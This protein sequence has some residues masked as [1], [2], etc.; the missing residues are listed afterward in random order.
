MNPTI[1]V[2]AA[3]GAMLATVSAAADESPECVYEDAEIHG[4]AIYAFSDDGQPVTIVLGGFEL[5][6]GERRVTG[7]DAVLWV[8]NV[9]AAGPD[10]HRITVYVEGRAEATGAADEAM[11]VHVLQQGRLSTAKPVRQRNL[12]GFPLYERA[13][14][15]RRRAA[16]AAATRPTRTRSAP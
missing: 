14:A 1:R 9:R 4:R 12:A 5:R 11:I 10:R 15:A 3:L 7:R 16:E 2:I 6:M 8:R 13:V